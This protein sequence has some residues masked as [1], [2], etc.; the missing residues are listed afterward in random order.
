MNRTEYELLLNK[1]T[2]DIENERANFKAFDD[3]DSFTKEQRRA[4]AGIALCAADRFY[5]HLSE[6]LAKL[7][8]EE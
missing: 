7:R 2:D 1:V 8:D 4:I 6:R 3:F 5:S